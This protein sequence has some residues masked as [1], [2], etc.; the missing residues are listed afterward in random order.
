MV[1]FG[2]LWF[3]AVAVFSYLSACKFGRKAKRKSPDK[4]MPDLVWIVIKKKMDLPDVD[5]KDSCLLL[6]FGLKKG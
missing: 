6:G 5:K 3:L 2:S 1:F 4:C